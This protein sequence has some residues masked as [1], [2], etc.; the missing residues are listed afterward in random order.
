MLLHIYV[1][2]SCDT[3]NFVNG[4][5]AFVEIDEFVFQTR[6]W[7]QKVHL[8]HHI[9]DRAIPVTKYQERKRKNSSRCVHLVVT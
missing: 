5:V 6:R 7:R 4:F 9:K 8:K 2:L 3:L 1:L